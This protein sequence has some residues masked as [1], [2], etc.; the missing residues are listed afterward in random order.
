MW[1][2]KKVPLEP[3]P[4]GPKPLPQLKQAQAREYQTKP[5]FISHTHSYG[6]ALLPGEGAAIAQYVQQNKRIPRRGEVGLSAEDIEH[7]E[8]V[9]F[10]MSGSRYVVLFSLHSPFSHKRMN[11]VRIRKESQ[12]Y[13][14]EEKRAL[15]IFNY[16]E[17][18][19]RENKILAGF[20]ELLQEKVQDNLTDNPQP[21][22]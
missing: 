15:A 7:Y 20:R 14:A 11:A 17:K 13:T 4:V 22:E 9:G 12:V 2:E 1:I 6:G 8:D 3:E 18:A 21:P 16:E 5:L 10:V 19:K